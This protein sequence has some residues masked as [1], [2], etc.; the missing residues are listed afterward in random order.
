VSNVSAGT[1]TA[2]SIETLT[3]NS[4]LTQSKLTD[5]VSDNA[6]AL[7]ITG[8]ANLQIVGDVDFADNF[9]NNSY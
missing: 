8:S 2:A 1:F 6:T 3:I 9:H 4:T 7:N 5:V